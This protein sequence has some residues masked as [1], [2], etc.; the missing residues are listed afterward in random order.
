MS[1][2]Y[3]E[4][5]MFALYSPT[6]YLRWYHDSLVKIKRNRQ[7]WKRTSDETN[8][9]GKIAVEASNGLRMA[10][11]TAY[12]LLFT[13]P[14]GGPEWEFHLIRGAA[15]GCADSSVARHPFEKKFTV[16][17]TDKFAV[18]RTPVN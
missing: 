11:F 17:F 15:G 18:P 16:R 12:S 5:A 13:V 6:I 1:S 7:F 4:S 9:D 14:G 2:W 3:G 8:G 10:E